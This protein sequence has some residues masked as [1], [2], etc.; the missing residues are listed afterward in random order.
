MLIYTWQF[1]PIFK[2]NTLFISRDNSYIFLSLWLLT[3]FWLSHDTFKYIL[4]WSFISDVLKFSV[5]IVGFCG[6]LDLSPTLNTLFPGL[7]SELLKSPNDSQPFYASDII[8]IA[9]GEKKIAWNDIILYFNALNQIWY[10]PCLF[11]FSYRCYGKWSRHHCYKL[12]WKS[13]SCLM[14]WCFPLR[15]RLIW[16]VDLNIPS[17]WRLKKSSFL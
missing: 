12:S 9:L 16:K 13:I 14:W 17:L 6:L 4:G 1:E 10:L 7:S 15:N 8:N 5:S 2:S 11:Q 3:S